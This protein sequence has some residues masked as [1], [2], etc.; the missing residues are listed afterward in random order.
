MSG[1]AVLLRRGSRKAPGHETAE[2]TVRRLGLET[3]EET[4]VRLGLKAAKQRRRR[5]SL[6]TAGSAGVLAF[7][8]IHWFEGGFWFWHLSR[9]SWYHRGLIAAGGI[10]AAAIAVS[11]Y[12]RRAGG[13]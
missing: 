1:R 9:E 10:V 7:A 12:R 6:A 13:S 2:Q 3:E 8:V 5:L 4:S 11:A